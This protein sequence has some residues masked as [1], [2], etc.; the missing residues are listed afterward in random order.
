MWGRIITIFTAIFSVDL[1][2]IEKE[3]QEALAAYRAA[4]DPE[5][6]GGGTY[7]YDE[8]KKIFNETVDVFEKLVPGVKE[9][10]Q[11]LMDEQEE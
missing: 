2:G 4:K 3:I 8:M 9:V 1:A 7:T 10:W 11:A 5:G 6:P